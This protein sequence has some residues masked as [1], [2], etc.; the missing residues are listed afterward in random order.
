MS[1]NKSVNEASRLPSRLI[2][3]LESPVCLR[4]T[5]LRLTNLQ[6]RKHRIYNIHNYAG[7]VDLVSATYA[8]RRGYDRK[9]QTIMPEF[10]FQY[11]C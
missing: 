5:E 7:Y 4:M 2:E 3:I 8:L 11:Y 1:D 6:Q 9:I 10:S